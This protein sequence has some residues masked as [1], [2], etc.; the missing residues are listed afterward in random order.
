MV[1]LKLFISHVKICLPC[2]SHVT[3]GTVPSK[4][5][6]LIPMQLRLA[7]QREE[8]VEGTSDCELFESP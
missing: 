5:Y 6:H 2:M 4:R 8:A 1:V 7:S 3:L